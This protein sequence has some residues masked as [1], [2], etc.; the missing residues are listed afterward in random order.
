[1]LPQCDF[2]NVFKSSLLSAQASNLH[3]ADPD[4]KADPYIVLRLGKNEIKDR[5]NYIPKQL[6]PV[7]G[8]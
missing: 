4:G 3:P 8:R 5:D 7:F 1:M 6:N 2:T